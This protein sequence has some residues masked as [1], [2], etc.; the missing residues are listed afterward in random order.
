MSL[1]CTHPVHLW[2]RS[3]ETTRRALPLCLSVAPSRSRSGQ[4][5]ARAPGRQTRWHLRTQL[6]SAAGATHRNVAADQAG[7]DGIRAYEGDHKIRDSQSAEYFL[8]C[9]DRLEQMTR[10]WSW[11]C[12]ETKRRRV[13]SQSKNARVVHRRF[14][15]HY[16]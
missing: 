3:A 6:L 4:T 10:E 11:W 1:S 2:G 9:M 7:T 13:L 16:R 12:S 5:R 15:A 14:I 8:R